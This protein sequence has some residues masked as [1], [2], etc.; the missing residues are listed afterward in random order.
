MAAA[1]RQRRVV[2]DGEDNEVG[3]RRQ[4]TVRNVIHG[5]PDQAPAIA[6]SLRTSKVKNG[7]A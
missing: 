2:G 1:Q 5:T 7:N 6:S 3:P 4:A